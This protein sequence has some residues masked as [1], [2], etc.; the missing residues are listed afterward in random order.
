MQRS[1]LAAEAY[2]N[3]VAKVT[4]LTERGKQWL[5]QAIDP[6]HDLTMRPDGYPDV[7]IAP[8]VSQL[9]KQTFNIKK[10]ASLP[11][12]N[13]DLNLFN[14]PWWTVD[15]FQQVSVDGNVIS[16]GSMGVSTWNLGGIVSVAGAE[17]AD[18]WTDTGPS[19]TAV[20]TSYGL[21]PAYFEG[22]TR[23]TGAGFETV[24]TTSKLYKQGQ[25]IVYRQPQS[26]FQQK[27]MTYWNV[28]GPSNTVTPLGA[29]SYVDVRPPPYNTAEA[30]LFTGSKQWEA[31]EGAYCV[32]SFNSLDIPADSESVIDPIMWTDGKSSNESG[33][34]SATIPTLYAATVAQYPSG[35]GYTGPLSPALTCMCPQDMSGMYFSGLSE[36]TTISL[37]LNVFIERFPSSDEP[38]LKT[39]AQCSPAYDVFA[40]QIYTYCLLD[41][42]PGV[43]AFMNGIGDWFASVVSKVSGAVSKIAGGIPHPIAQAVS[44]GAGV[45]SGASA[46]FTDPPNTRVDVKTIKR[47]EQRAES[48]PY[49]SSLPIDIPLR[50]TNKELDRDQQQDNAI[51]KLRRREQALSQ[52]LAALKIRVAKGGARKGKK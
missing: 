39:L 52:E 8:S 36:Q 30:M 24:N 43:P 27:V 13:W 46:L 21:D 29:G 3:H 28:V 33:P 15:G 4:Q 22:A 18:L 11:A 10:P 19:P 47:N 49:S 31:A 12:G 37:T 38:D 7:K 26:N 44:Q 9:V 25:V 41:M 17:G 40:Q 1:G 20:V 14:L 16:V 48:R 2:L 5:K 35:I 6:M 42:P 23:V 51:R 32:V 45:V 34:V 50:V